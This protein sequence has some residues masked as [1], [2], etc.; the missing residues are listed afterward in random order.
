MRPTKPK[1]CN[2]KRDIS[3]LLEQN[4]HILKYKKFEIE[5]IE[6]GMSLALVAKEVPSD[7]SIVYVP[8]PPHIRVSKPA[9]NFAKHI[10]DLH[11]EIRRN[12]SL[13]NEYKL[14]ADMHR[15]SKEFNVGDYVMVCIRPER[16][17]KMFSKKLYARAMGPYSIIRKMGFNAYLLDLSNDIDI[18]HVFNVEDLLPYQGTFEP[19]TLPSSVSVGETSKGVPTMPSLQYSKETVDITLDDEFVTSKD[20]G[21]HRFLVKWHG[22]LDS[23]VTWIQEDNLRH[24]DHSLLD[25]YLSFHS[26]ES[27]SFQPGGNDGA[28]SRPKRDKQPKSNDKFYYY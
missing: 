8:L 3:K 27:S 23:D 11:V 25:C 6:T 24:L 9:E 15:R 19:S 17:P 1:G 4:L 20:D 7:S 26:S 18:S 10:Y 2:G 28:W 14:A 13:S 12:I 21:F 22:R 5:G 16:I